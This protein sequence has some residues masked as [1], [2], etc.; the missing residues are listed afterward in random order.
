MALACVA[1]HAVELLVRQPPEN[2]LWSCNVASLLAALGLLTG[3][4]TVN[5]AGG[6]LLLAGEPVWLVDLASGGSLE[7]TSLLTHLGVAALALVGM[8]RLGVPRRAWPAAV[9][10][11]A[12]ATIAA[13]LTSSA[14]QNV[15]LA[16]VTPPGWE[17]FPSHGV[18]LLWL[19]GTICAGMLG[20][21][22]A[23]RRWLPGAKLTSPA[24]PAGT[25]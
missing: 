23:I 16:V 4:A 24:S 22:L 15:N 12:V 6:L 7:A 17:W 9:V 13:A 14:A 2:L 21:M 5:A 18:Y 10:A 25:R 11:L 19:G 20:L 3:T 8:R 1:A